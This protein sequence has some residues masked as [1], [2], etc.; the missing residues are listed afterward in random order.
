MCTMG[1][2]LYAVCY[3]S[4]LRQ[5]DTVIS[6]VHCH[7]LQLEQYMHPSKIILTYRIQPD[8]W[9]QIQ[10]SGSSQPMVYGHQLS[11]DFALHD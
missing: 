5:D 7:C 8:P 6:E 11:M 3:T 2:A 1:T 9:L 10:I 4:H